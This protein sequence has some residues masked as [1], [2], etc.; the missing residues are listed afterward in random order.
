MPKK[1]KSSKVTPPAAPVARP[2]VITSVKRTR[3][4][5]EI[6]WTQ[7]DASFDL[8]ER[9]NPLPAFTEALTN[10]APVVGEICHFQK[11]YCEAGLRCVGLTMSEQGG[12]DVVSLHAR[13]DID[14]AAKEFAFKTPGRLL[15]HPTT[16]GRYTPP[17]SAA[18]A[19]LVHEAVEQAK[20]YVRGER[21]Q[22]QIEFE[23]EDGDGHEDDKGEQLPL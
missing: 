23:D 20:A 1:N 17:L 10:L 4:T 19:A 7:G 9:D 6:A 22:G 3:K 16:E 15:S 5:I 11:A 21:A 18:D 2:I 8:S 13:K 14:D 12:A